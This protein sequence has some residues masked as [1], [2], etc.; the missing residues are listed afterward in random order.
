MPSK[1]RLSAI[2]TSKLPLLVSGTVA[3]VSTQVWCRML[4]PTIS[5]APTSE[6]TARIPP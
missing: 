5:D 4:P 2:A 1:I 6:I 3:V